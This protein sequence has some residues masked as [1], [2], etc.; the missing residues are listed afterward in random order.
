MIRNDKIRAY[1]VETGELITELTENKNGTI[2][3][4]F[5]DPNT[6]KSLISCTVNGEISF[7]KLD[8]NI[9]TQKKVD[10]TLF[11]I[12]HSLINTFHF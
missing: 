1:S 8:S 2:V 6:K 5:L 10:F 4:L 11:L 7:W 9:I 3:G 12:I